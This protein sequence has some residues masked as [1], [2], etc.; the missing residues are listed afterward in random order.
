MNP[1]KPRDFKYLCP[2]PISLLNSF[3]NI[4]TLL[5]YSI[6]STLQKR[7]EL[8]CIT[9]FGT[10][11]SAWIEKRSNNQASSFL[12]WLVCGGSHWWL[13]TKTGYRP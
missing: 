9:V 11:A 2:T 1:A 7:D 10:G 12:F 13:A 4:A 8:T 5:P 3:R 6:K